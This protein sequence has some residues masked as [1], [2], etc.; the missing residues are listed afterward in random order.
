VQGA[1]ADSGGLLQ[2]GCTPL[3]IAAANGDFEVVRILVAAEADKNAPTKVREWRGG[4]G[5]FG[6]QT[7]HVFLAG[8]C[9][10]AADCQLSDEVW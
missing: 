2:D 10:E 9:S 6:A 7:V 5:M 1:G 8:G 4:E 3:F